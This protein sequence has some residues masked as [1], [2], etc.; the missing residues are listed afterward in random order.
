MDFEAFQFRIFDQGPVL[1][2]HSPVARFVS[3]PGHPPIDPKR[4]AHRLEAAWPGSSVQPAKELTDHDLYARLLEGP[5]E[6][7][8]VRFGLEDKAST[9]VHI[10]RETGQIVEV[11]DRSRRLYRWLYN[12]LHSFDL[13]F[14]AHQPVLRKALI[15]VLLFPG[16]LLS[17]TSL[18]LAATRLRRSL[19]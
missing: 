12:G 2:G 4:I 8:V 18:V 10:D 17:L 7:S 11:M 14:L 6:P 15:L 1:I 5:L 19:R 16:L 13:P 3:T 9:W